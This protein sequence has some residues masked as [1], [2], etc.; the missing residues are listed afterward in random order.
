MIAAAPGC[1]GQEGVHLHGVRG[2]AIHIIHDKGFRPGGAH[3][4]HFDRGRSLAGT[5]GKQSGRANY[6]QRQQNR[7]G[8]KQNLFVH[9][10]LLKI[11]NL[12]RKIE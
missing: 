12:I 2:N 8:R 10:F 7:K 11:K 1:T 9:F 3:I 6:G 4:G 5:A